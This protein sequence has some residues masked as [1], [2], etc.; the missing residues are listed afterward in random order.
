M[1][2]MTTR[3]HTYTCLLAHF[4][5]SFASLFILMSFAFQLLINVWNFGMI[6]FFIRWRQDKRYLNRKKKNIDKSQWV[7]RL[8]QIK[9]AIYI[10]IRYVE[11]INGIRYIFKTKTSMNQWNIFNTFG[12]FAFGSGWCVE[13][14][15]RYIK[16]KRNGRMVFLLLFDAIKW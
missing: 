8:M 3:R 7:D 11:L 5:H 10:Y 15:S 1:N 13:Y 2:I 14:I 16:K 9:M 4:R 12:S 6:F